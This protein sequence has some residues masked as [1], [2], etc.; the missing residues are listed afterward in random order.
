MKKKPPAPIPVLVRVPPILLKK[1]DAVSKAQGRSRTSEVCIR[2]AESFKRPKA[3][4][5]MVA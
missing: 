3:A 2:L 5:K 4:E 1:L